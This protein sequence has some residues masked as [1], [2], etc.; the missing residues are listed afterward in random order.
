MK[1]MKL[2]LVGTTA[3][4]LS[5]GAA[6]AQ[7]WTS[8]DERQA[9]LD[10]RIDDG[11]R[12]GD[13]TR[14]EAERLRD[15]F[16]DLAR[17]EGRYRS[18]GLSAAE[19]ADL[20]QKFDALA[21]QIRIERTDASR[22]DGRASTQEWMSI[23]QRQA[24]L[25]QRIDVG[26]RN[27]RLTRSEAMRLRDDFHDLARLEARYRTD[28]LSGWERADLDRRFDSLEARIRTESADASRD[29]YGGRDWR[30]SRGAW[31]DINR[32]QAQLDRRIDQG[33]RSGQLS[34]AEARRLRAEFQAI[35]RMENT[36]RRGGL[37]VSERADLDQRF[38]LLAQHIRSERRDDDRRYGYNRPR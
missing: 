6:S 24:R 13:L 11:V 38:D 7:T 3:L 29:W 1:F 23:N 37:T 33:V 26:V 9:R 12:T 31:V 34:Q 27:G 22:G 32:R 2:A 15:D 19:R 36:Y 25:D 20:D 17:L 10:Q 16:R 35:A 30:D 8:I 5:A 21:A 14:T 18:D 28:G 4:M